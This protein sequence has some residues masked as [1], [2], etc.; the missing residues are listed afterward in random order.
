MSNK[1]TITLQAKTDDAK[2][3]IASL[4]KDIKSLTTSVKSQSEIQKTHYSNIRSALNEQ[5]KENENFAKRR[6]QIIQDT[7]TSNRQLEES[8][9]SK[10]NP[11]KEQLNAIEQAKSKMQNEQKALLSSLGGDSA[12]ANEKQKEQLNK[13]EQDLSNHINEIKR[14]KKELTEVTRSQDYQDLSNQISTNKQLKAENLAKLQAEKQLYNQSAKLKIDNLKQEQNLNAQGLADNRKVLS[15]KQA[16]LEKEVS[17]KQQYEKQLLKLEEKANID[18][19]A[20]A[21]KRAMEIK[22]KNA[23]Q[24]L[25][26]EKDYKDKLFEKQRSVDLIVDEYNQQVEATKLAQKQ[27]RER[28]A[29]RQ[30]AK[31]KESFTSPLQESWN[32]ADMKTYYSEMEKSSKKAYDVEKQELDKLASWKMSKAKESFN[33]PYQE[34]W[35][36]KDMKNYYAQMEQSSKKAYEERELFKRQFINTSA[37]NKYNDT[38]ARLNELQSRGIITSK[39]K[40][41]ALAKEKLNVDATEKSYS[42]LANT[43]IRYL[44]WAGTIAGVFYGVQRAWQMTLG[45]GIDVN[46]MIEDNTS[47]IAALISANTRMALSNGQMVN[48]YEKFQIASGKAASIME[49]LRVA[50]TKTYATFPQLTGIYQQMIGH[51]MSMGDSM[52]KTVNEISTNTIELSKILSNIGGAIG[53]EMQKVN[54]EARSIISGSAST[55]SLIAMMVFGSPTQA[56]EAMKKAKE[57]GTNGVK[58]MLMGVLESYKVLEGV[59]TYTRAQLELQDQISRSQEL[60]SKPTYNALKDVY[61]DLSVALKQNEKDFQIWGERLLNISKEV[62][63]YAD[64]VAKVVIAYKS[65]QLAMGTASAFATGLGAANAAAALTFTGMVVPIMAVVSAYMAYDKWIGSVLR[66][67]ESLAKLKGKKES[68]LNASSTGSVEE[69]IKIIQK[70]IVDIIDKRKELSAVLNNER[71]KFGFKYSEEEKKSAQESDNLAKQEY[72]K[73]LQEKKAREDILTTRA[74]IL[75]KQEEINK[76]QGQEAELLTRLGVDKKLEEERKSFRESNEKEIV[77][78]TKQRVTWNEDILRQ[79]RELAEVRKQTP[80]DIEYI[81]KKEKEIAEEKKDILALDGKIA[82]VN[83]QASDKAKTDADAIINKNEKLNEELAKRKA[84]EFEIAALSAGTYE[85]ETYKTEQAKLQVETLIEQYKLLQEGDAKQ[86]ALR[87]ILKSQL[88]YEKAITTQKEKQDEAD[89]KALKFSEIKKYI[90]FSNLD[91]EGAVQL[92]AG[93]KYTFEGDTESLVSLDKEIDKVKKQLYKEDLTLNIKFEGFNDVTNGIAEIGNSFQ[94]MQQAA[95]EYNK[96]LKD[97][98]A[99][100]TKLKQAQLDYSSATIN[101]YGDMIG[102]IGNFYDEDD[103]RREKQQKLAEAFHYIKMAQQLSEMAQSTAFTSLFVAQESAKSTAA[104]VTAVATAAQSSPWTGFATAAA[105]IALLASIGLALGGSSAKTSVSSDSL[106]SMKANTGTGTVLGDTEA[107]SESIVNALSILEDFAEPQYQTLLSMNK[108][109]SAIASG[110]G[111]VS[112]LLVQEGGYAFGQGFKSTDSGWQQKVSYNGAMSA[113]ISAV[114]GAMLPQAAVGTAMGMFGGSAVVGAVNSAL[115]A[116]MSTAMVG[117]LASTGVGLAVAAVDKLLLDGAINKTVGKVLNPILGG[118]FGK[119]S[120]S[121]KMKDSGMYFADQLLTEATKNFVGS[122]YQTIETTTTKKSW[123]SKSTDTSSKTKTQ[124]LS[125]QT[126]NQFTM[127]IDNLYKTT[128]L[129]GQAL[130]TATS[131]VEDRLK[132]FVVSIGKISLYKKSGDE[133]QKTLEAIFGKLGDQIAATAFPL[134]KPFQAVGEGMFETMTRVATGMEEAKFYIDKL[135]YQFKEIPYWLVANKQGNVGF[136]ALLQSI[137]RADQATNGLDN[138]LIKVISSLDGTA[139]ELYGTYTVLN[140]LRNTFK[141]LN[142]GAET[143]SFNSIRGAGG[144]EALAQGVEAYTQNF[145]TEADQLSLSTSLMQKEFNKLNIAMPVGKDGFISLINGIDKTTASGQE[146]YGRLIILSEGFANVADS[147]EESIKLLESTLKDETKKLFDD[148][149]S[150]ISVM[151]DAIVSMAESTENTI[152]NIKTRDTGNKQETIYNQFVEYNKLLAKFEA[153]QISGDMK[154][155]ESSYSSILGLSSTLSEAGYQTEIVS[156]LENKLAGFDSTKDILRVNIVDGLGVLLE[157]TQE[158]TSQL[159]LAAKDGVITN[160]ELTSIKNLTQTQK[161]GV[162]EFANNSNYL[163]TEDTLSNLEAYAAAQLDLLK[164]SQADDKERLSSKTF[165]T[166]DYIGTQ[167][168]IDIAKRLGVSYSAA[169]PM[170]E[171]LQALNPNSS[172]LQKE[173][174]EMIGYDGY[175]FDTSKAGQLESL[176]EFIDPKIFQALSGVK[177]QSIANIAERERILKAKDDFLESVLLAETKLATDQKNYN[178]NAGQYNYYLEKEE[179]TENEDNYKKYKALRYQ[180]EIAM[181]KNVADIGSDK[182]SIQGLWDENISNKYFENLY[183]ELVKI[184]A[185]KVNPIGTL[186]TKTLAAKAGFAKG[187][188]TGDMP[189]NA[190]AGFV[191]GQEYVLD[192]NATSQINSIG[193]VTDMVSRYTNTN[194]F[195]RELIDIKNVILDQSKYFNG[196]IIELKNQ[197]RI[198]TDSKDILNTSLEVLEEIEKVA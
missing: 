52:G 14:L 191:H 180:F 121:S 105:M 124:A 114:S 176:S 51:T 58:D 150:S 22:N 24:R 46:K 110:I 133:I 71:G 54:E 198:L 172:M 178:Y 102:A 173:V 87:D 45:A 95:S 154:T 40:D 158:Q 127:I 111:G 104:G 108:Y 60:L 112:S 63:S 143:L 196:I 37:E 70:G 164:T 43:T 107:Q 131:E 17:N 192:S 44:R 130:G 39:E 38:L 146:L 83:K 30:M 116:G 78:L 139:E 4:E 128:L 115:T 42:N 85:T 53:M 119:T 195:T 11:L 137:I 72:D 47:G 125:A 5:N 36:T 117:A 161:D 88:E 94:D 99:S 48:S 135:G 26:N 2:K 134:L 109:L 144:V 57:N 55:D 23:E 101:G 62:V 27:E 50:S 188:Y 28:L 153:A 65:L 15:E 66:Q 67:E 16:L 171:S 3:N 141:F 89:R 79:E 100:P 91:M 186:Y 174:G 69:E 68:D 56:N 168:Q 175:E 123:F 166:G 13:R 170:I 136:E 183:S 145:L 18:Y 156:L 21:T 140:T 149:I 157:L 138:N 73:L 162:L 155:A 76:A 10:T 189:T 59:K 122:A 9:K 187:G 31:A 12:K 19:E 129:A 74:N 90:D 167:E 181:N 103:H 93:L 64:D 197:I 61:M 20:I 142:V 113:G 118:I 97:K 106:S 120:V 25:Q 49:E 84:I 6:Q 151:F 169:K 7:I 33:K 81:A 182:A 159:Q 80:N 35:D 147:V 152:F 184:N 177:S 194:G 190:I 86:T 163:S 126:N 96:V 92:E 185:E 41:T 1:I 160:Q 77:K 193:S 8:M 132:N 165:T 179:D 32:T 82:E 98:D 29:P 75:K 148:F 34:S